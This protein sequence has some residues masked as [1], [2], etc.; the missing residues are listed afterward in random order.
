MLEVNTALGSDHFQNDVVVQLILDFWRVLA[1][2]CL[3][4]TFG[5]ELGKNV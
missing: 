2:E 1:I 3:E 4:N 5:V